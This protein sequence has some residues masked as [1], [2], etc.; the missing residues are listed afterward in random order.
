M[1]LTLA[2][3]QLLRSIVHNHGWTLMRNHLL[4]EIT[5]RFPGLNSQLDSIK[6][7]LYVTRQLKG[8]TQVDAKVSLHPGSLEIVKENATDG[9]TPLS[10][11]L[12]GTFDVR[13][14]IRI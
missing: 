12:Q 14:I 7:R 9:R 6:V 1:G 4:Q 3:F 8:S 10:H 11:A 2:W 5:Y 13:Q